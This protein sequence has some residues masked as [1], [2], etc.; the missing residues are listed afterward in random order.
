MIKIINKSNTNVILFELFKKYFLF[1]LK[2]LSVLKYEENYFFR[3]YKN[4]NN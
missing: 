4:L 2:K 3:K 1:I